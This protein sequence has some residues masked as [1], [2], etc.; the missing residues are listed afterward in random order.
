[1]RLAVIIF[2]LV[3]ACSAEQN[4]PAFKLTFG[5][6]NDQPRTIKQAEQ[7]GWIFMSG[8][9]SDM[10]FVGHRYADPMDPSLVI[11]FD[12]AGY[13]AGVQSFALE[14]YYDYAVSDPS[15]NPSYNYGFWFAQPAWITT[16]YFVDPTIICNGGRSEEEFNTQG[17]GDRVAIQ[18]GPTP[19]DLINVPLT[20]SEAG[21]DALWYDHLCFQA[22]GDHW[23]NFNYE[24]DQDCGTVLPF[25]ILYNNDGN[26]IGFV[27]Q[28]MTNL[29]GD[30]WEH[31]DHFAVSH[32]VDRP[33]T[34]VTEMVDYPG[35][36]TMH[37]YFNSE[38]WT[39]ACP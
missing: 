13:I 35:L 25:Q 39:F 10:N 28:H 21:N 1:M 34:C 33:P 12:D 30:K 37:H 17:S 24:P 31:P 9:G 22:M 8:C 20:T 3:A 38:P 27:W 2:A 15:V 36:S 23:L 11:I 14:E 7:M 19:A 26:L 4:W 18:Y 16:A 32:I 5:A 6:F 29:P